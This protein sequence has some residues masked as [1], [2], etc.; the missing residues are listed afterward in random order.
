MGETNLESGPKSFVPG[1]ARLVH[2][3]FA[4][5]VGPGETDLVP[6]RIASFHRARLE[7]IGVMGPVGLELSGNSN[8]A[9]YA[10]GD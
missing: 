2:V 6:R 4:D 10:V 3:F 8:T 5:Q 9:D 7:A 1:T